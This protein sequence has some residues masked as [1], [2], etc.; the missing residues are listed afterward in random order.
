MWVWVV[1]YYCTFMSGCLSKF[2]RILDDYLL[3]AVNSPIGSL[4]TF[5]VFSVC[6]CSLFAI[7]ILLFLFYYHSIYFNGDLQLYS[8]FLQYYYKLLYIKFALQ[9]VLLSLFSLFTSLYY[10]YRKIVF[11]KRWTPPFA[12]DFVSAPFCVSKTQIYEGIEN[13]DT[14]FRPALRSLLVSVAVLIY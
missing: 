6:F 12:V 14:F 8:Y 9:K 5:Y 4:S 11:N 10:V 2:C 3:W 1:L 7:F 13:P